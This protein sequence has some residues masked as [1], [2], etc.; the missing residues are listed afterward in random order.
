MQCPDC[1][2]PNFPKAYLSLALFQLKKATKFCQPPSKHRGVTEQPLPGSDPRFLPSSFIT[3]FGLTAAPPKHARAH[4]CTCGHAHSC[5]RERSH[6]HPQA[7]RPPSFA[8]AGPEAHPVPLPS[9]AGGGASLGEG[10]KSHPPF[11]RCGSLS[12]FQDPSLSK[13]TVSPDHVGS[14]PP[15]HLHPLCLC[16]WPFKSVITHYCTEIRL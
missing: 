1:G 2:F 16:L 5:T 11:P 13:L 7:H 3:S 4:T 12:T 9:V 14:P 10:V 15:P 8:A 6:L